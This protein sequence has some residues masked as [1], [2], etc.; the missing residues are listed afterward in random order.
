MKLK[1]IL[2][3]SPFLRRPCVIWGVPIDAMQ[4]PCALRQVQSLRLP[5][6]VRAPVEW[7][8]LVVRGSL[9]TTPRGVKM[10]LGLFSYLVVAVQVHFF[11]LFLCIK[12]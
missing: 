2:A 5:G 6:A 7:E 9:S 4:N 11:A 10:P 12:C 1:W 8:R 3:W